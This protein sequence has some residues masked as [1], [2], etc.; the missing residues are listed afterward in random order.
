[1]WEVNL[2][3]RFSL[4]P[5][6]WVVCA[7][8]VVRCFLSGCGAILVQMRQAHDPFWVLSPHLAKTYITTSRTVVG[9]MC[10]RQSRRVIWYG[11]RSIHCS[12]H[13]S[14]RTYFCHFPLAF[15]NIYPRTLVPF[16]QISL[17]TSELKTT[18]N[19]FRVC[20]VRVFRQP[21]SK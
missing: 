3:P 2:V 20:R 13:C 10:T 14:C 17:K 4:L 1:M 11:I 8:C 21:S 9:K 18:H 6:K 7:L 5:V 16:C 15:A 19:T 12:W